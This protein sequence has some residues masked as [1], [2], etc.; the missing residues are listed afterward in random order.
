[1][2]VAI[3]LANQFYLPLSRDPLFH[4]STQVLDWMNTDGHGSMSKSSL[5]SR[6][7]VARMSKRPQRCGAS[8]FSYLS[9]QIEIAQFLDE[10]VADIVP[11]Q[12]EQ[13]IGR[14]KTQL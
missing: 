2:P 12:G 8:M 3:Y 7:G 4:L 6:V 10:A 14:Q 11:V 13:H 5:C 1:M 9:A